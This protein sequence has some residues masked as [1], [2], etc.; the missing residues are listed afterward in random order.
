M[1][2]ANPVFSHQSDVVWTLKTYFPQIFVLTGQNTAEAT[3]GLRTLEFRWQ[4]GKNFRNALSFYLSIV[5][6]LKTFRPDIVFS[7]MTEVQSA[8]A[9]PILKLLRIRHVLWYAHKSNSIWLRIAN[10]F[11]DCLV[12]STKGSIPVDG[13]KVFLIGQGIDVGKFKANITPRKKTRFLHVGRNDAS[14]NLYLISSTLLSFF[15]NKP[16][17]LDHYGNSYDD[18]RLESLDYHSKLQFL[19][20]ENSQITLHPAIERNSLTDVFARYD[21]FIH[22]FNGSLDKVL[23]EAVISGIPVVTINQE[24]IQLFG[25]WSKHLESPSLY[26]ELAAFMTESAESIARQSLDRQN[27]AIEQFGLENW[28]RKLIEVLLPD[29]R[30]EEIH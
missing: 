21:V 20:T 27:L 24:F 5:N 26:Q 8:L 25:K 3:S 13:D 7:H 28:T 23:V 14:K 4:E 15:R 29:T 6:V 11:C 12:S 1:N 30:S 9:A 18:N 16:F 10:L 19:V 17:S 22:A 2:T